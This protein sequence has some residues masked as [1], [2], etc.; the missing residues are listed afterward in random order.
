MNRAVAAVRRAWSRVR[1]YEPM[2]GGRAT[3]DAEYAAGNWDYLR[4]LSELSRFSVIAGYCQ[5]LKPG[6]SIL[7]VGCGEGLL[8]DRL[9]KS[10]YSRYVGVDISTVAIERAAARQDA[11]TTFAA[12]DAQT[13]VPSATFDLILFNECLEYFDDP[14]GLVRRY[15][16]SLAPGGLYIA[17]IF[18]GIDTA[19]SVKIWRMLAAR[20]DDLALT[21]LK[22]EEGFCW[23][24]KVLRASAR[25]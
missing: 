18:D 17:S 22:N 12:A 15:E 20:Y 11:A 1:P 8:T 4:A 7:E 13:F 19:R 10:K 23:S 25:A 3:L 21:R 2:R 5:Q 6:G 24:I 9:D 14:A 16:A